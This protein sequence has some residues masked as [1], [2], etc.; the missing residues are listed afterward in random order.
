[1][2]RNER[3][4]SFEKFSAKLQAAYNELEASGRPEHNGNIVDR[5]WGKIQNHELQTYLAAL[6]VD[7]KKQ[8]RS[9]VEIL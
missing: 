6:Q 7:Y 4:M 8:A 1:M 3:A 5:L 2:Y 9:Y